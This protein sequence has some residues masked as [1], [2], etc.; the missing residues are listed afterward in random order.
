MDLIRQ[1]LLPRRDKS[2]EREADGPPQQTETRKMFGAGRS[3][4]AA[5]VL[6]DLAKLVSRERNSGHTSRATH[7]ADDRW[8]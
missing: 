5:K 7:S 1:Q 3:L 6:R 4:L 8:W 2:M